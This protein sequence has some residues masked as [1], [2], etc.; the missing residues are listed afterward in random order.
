MAVWGRYTSWSRRQLT[1]MNLYQWAGNKR[2]VSLKPE[3]QSS[4]RTTSSGMTISTNPKPTIYRNFYD[5]S[6]NNSICDIFIFINYNFFLVN[7]WFKKTK[8]DSDVST[9][10]PPL[11]NYQKLSPESGI[12]TMCHHFI[13]KA[14][15]CQRVGQGR[16]SQSDWPRYEASDWSRCPSWPIR[17]LISG[18]VAFRMPLLAGGGGGIADGHVLT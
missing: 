5:Y 1:I 17:C 9:Y 7:C 8:R 13:P 12:N 10:P 11:R 16:R 4:V 6:S 14:D 15:T 3:Y 18:P 2:L